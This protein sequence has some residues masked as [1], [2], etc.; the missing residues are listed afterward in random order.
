MLLVVWFPDAGLIDVGLPGG[1]FA[2]VKHAPDSDSNNGRP[3]M[4]Q[5]KIFVL[6]VL[7]LNL[8]CDYDRIHELANNHKTIRQMLGHATFADE[9]EY[10]LQTLK[11][12]VSLLTPETLDRIN[13]LVVNAGHRLV[14]KKEDEKLKG[15]CDSFVVETNVHYPTDIN[16]LFDAWRSKR[17]VPYFIDDRAPNPDIRIGLELGL[18]RRIEIA[19]RSNQSNRPG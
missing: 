5:W 19:S 9:Y 16:L 10:K 15:R 14:K 1:V 4:E 8:N 18:M 17:P 13:E 11:D 12:N 7:R 2:T 6:G 3:G